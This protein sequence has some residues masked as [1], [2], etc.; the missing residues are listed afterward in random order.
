[1]SPEAADD[2]T[3]SLAIVGVGFRMLLLLHDIAQGAISSGQ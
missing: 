1:M 3:V 2:T